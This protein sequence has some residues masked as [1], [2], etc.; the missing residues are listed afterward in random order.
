MS[1]IP[2]V[3]EKKALDSAFAVL[4]KLWSWHTDPI[5]ENKELKARLN[6]KEAFERKKAEL[7][8]RQEDDNLYKDAAGR[9]YCPLCIEYDSKFVSV[10]N[11]FEGSY[12][13][14]LHKQVFETEERR[15]RNRNRRQPQ[16]PS[17]GGHREHWMR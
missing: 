7:V 4:R 1:P 12:Y 5:K 2:G 9:Y 16:Q 14:V 10:V 13:C 17:Y 15:L 11:Q 8:S 6:V 3:V